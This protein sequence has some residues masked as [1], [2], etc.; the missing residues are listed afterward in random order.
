MRLDTIAA[1]VRVPGRRGH[2]QPTTSSP[3]DYEWHVQAYNGTD[4]FISSGGTGT[5]T[6]ATAARASPLDSYRAAHHRQRADR[7]RRDRP[8]SATR[9]CP[10]PARTCAR[11]RCSAGTPRTPTSAT[12]SSILS[13]DGELTNL[14]KT[15][16]RHLDDV[17]RHASLSPTARPGRRTSGPSLPCTADG[18]L[19]PAASTPTTRSTSRAA[20][21]PG[22]P[23]ARGAGRRTTS[24][25]P[26]T[27]T[28][29]ARRSSTVSTRTPAPR[30]TRRPGPRR[31]YYRIQTS[32]DPNF[33]TG[34]TT[35]SVD[36]RTF[37]S[38]ADTYP[39]GTTYWRVQAVDG[40][41]NQLAWSTPRSFVKQSPA[42]VLSL[43]TAGQH[44]AGDSTLSWQPLD[45]ASNYVVEV[46][47]DNDM[48]PNT[49]NRVVNVTTDGSATCWTPWTRPPGPTPGGSGATTPRA[50]SAR[51]ARCR[52]SRSASR[53]R[54]CW[55]PR[56][57]ALV[58]P[59]D[60][61]FTWEA[62]A[63]A[64]KY[65]FERRK[66]G[67]TTVVEPITTP[68][69]AAAPTDAI[70]GGSWEWRVVALDTAGHTPGRRRPGGRSRS[71]TPPS[72]PRPV[73]ITGSGAVGDTADPEPAHLEHARAPV[74][75]TYQWYR[76]TL[77]DQRPDR[78][79]VR[80]VTR[81]RRQGADRARDRGPARATRPARRP[82]TRSP[83]RYHVVN[84]DVGKAITVR[85][86]GVRPGYKTGT[87]TSN[88]ITG[89]LGPTIAPTSRRRSPA[90]RPAR[91]SRP[92]RAPGR[93][94][95]RTPTSGSSTAS[96]SPRQTTSEYVV[97]TR[98]AGLPV[99]VRVTATTT[100]Y[101]PG[102]AFSASKTWRSCRRRPPRPWRRKT[103]TQRGRARSSR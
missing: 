3:G 79:D 39:E 41:G 27:T 15:V 85:A 46:Y 74:T 23:A 35:T 45:F 90:W 54:H 101:P 6:I 59:S 89:A 16:S 52:P 17:D 88:A 71:S 80:V 4:G 14:V 58:E 29:T 64:A 99:K 56:P 18:H 12:T 26:G 37:T 20:R 48:V 8:T 69:L 100:G 32:T 91:R 19:P 55:R 53:R 21:S 67:T 42:P 84:A 65:R 2:R 1:D 93:A 63:G 33:V 30:W 40:S 92:T 66:S 81:R 72:R 97:R 62:L 73:S 82:A 83:V 86:T 51:G 94:A 77:R 13:R 49:A 96:P 68:A 5:F 10:R 25:S 28:W 76:G 61:L 11:P 95:R 87:S 43:P 34:V 102:T 50:G 47:K 60:G 22:L 24:P 31:E 57:S 38:F 78:H 103:I 7:Q 44:G 75:T 98:D 70:A 36:Q 9:R